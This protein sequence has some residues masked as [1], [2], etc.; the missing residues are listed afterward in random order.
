MGQLSLIARFLGPTWGPSGPDRTQV[1]PMLAPWTLLSGMGCL[2]WMFGRKSSCYN[3]ID[4]VLTSK[5]HYRFGKWHV[6]SSLNRNA[7][8][9]KTN[10]TKWRDLI[11]TLRL[12]QKHFPDFIFNYILFGSFVFSCKLYLILIM[13]LIPSV[14][15]LM[16]PCDYTPEEHPWKIMGKY[17]P[18]TPLKFYIQDQKHAKQKCLYIVLDRWYFRHRISARYTARRSEASQRYC[19][20]RW[21]S[22][23]VITL[24]VCVKSS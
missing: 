5:L 22:Q 12:E 10:I 8:K 2:F 1:G 19:I 17:I 16:Q 3:A 9:N 7:I 23:N 11:T 18:E 4:N 21:Y 13:P 24:N 20:E 6:G 15:A 14:L